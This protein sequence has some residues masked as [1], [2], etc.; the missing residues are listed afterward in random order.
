[1]SQDDTEMVK[2]TEAA[3]M[4]FNQRDWD[5][6]FAHAAPE[7]EW[8]PMEENVSY[9]GREA[10]TG[11][12]ND[13]LEAWDEFEIETEDIELAPGTGLIWVALRYR[14]RGKGSEITVDGLFFHVL[15]V[16]DGQFLG[17]KEYTD[18]AEAL[19]AAG[20]SE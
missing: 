3:Y 14:G 20:L 2:R 19:E 12:L 6:F 16:R 13:W 7:Y 15:R 18:K 1:M 10:V 4:V 8:D 9:R 17:G 11:Y 5:G